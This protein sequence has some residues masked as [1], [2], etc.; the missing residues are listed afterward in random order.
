METQTTTCFVKKNKHTG[1]NMVFGFKK[2]TKEKKKKYH[3]FVKKHKV[4]VRANI[5]W[6]EKKKLSPDQNFFF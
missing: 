6:F 4:G 3:L 2:T 5:F 1:A